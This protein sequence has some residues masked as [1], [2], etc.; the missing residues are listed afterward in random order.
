MRFSPK[1]SIKGRFSTI[2]A[3]LLIAQSLCLRQVNAREL[4]CSSVTGNEIVDYLLNPERAQQESDRV[5]QLLQQISSNSTTSKTTVSCAADWG[6]YKKYLKSCDELSKCLQP[7]HQRA[8][9][10]YTD[11][12]AK[13]KASLP[14]CPF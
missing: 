10:I 2:T 6:G 14:K 5:D 9:G 3:I 11:I 8:C 12:Q 1:K 7:N 13:L 4:P